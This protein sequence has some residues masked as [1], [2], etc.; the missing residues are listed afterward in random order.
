[1]RN[2]GAWVDPMS[3]TDRPLGGGDCEIGTQQLSQG[4]PVIDHSLLGC[5]RTCAI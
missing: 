4:A 3:R 1:M 5:P 2:G